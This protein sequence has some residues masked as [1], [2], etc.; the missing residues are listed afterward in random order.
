MN[1]EETPFDDVAD[2]VVRDPLGTVLPD[3]IA[4]I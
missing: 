1:A 4:R 2:T 3:L